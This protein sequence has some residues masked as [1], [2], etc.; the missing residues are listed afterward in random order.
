MSWN[1]LRGLHS[2]ERKSLWSKKF[3]A[4]SH[5]PEIL[6]KVIISCQTSDPDATGTTR[7]ELSFG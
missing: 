5:F 7:V 4:A 6:P 1:S 3:I 2:E